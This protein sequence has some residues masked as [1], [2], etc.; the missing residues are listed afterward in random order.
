MEIRLVAHTPSTLELL[1]NGDC[2]S[3]NS[4]THVSAVERV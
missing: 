1:S 3:K 2:W 4:F